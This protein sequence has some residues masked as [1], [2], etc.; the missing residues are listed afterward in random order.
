M[1]ASDP[2]I[3]VANYVRMSAL[4]VVHS[5]ECKLAKPIVELGG[6]LPKHERDI[7]ARIKPVL[8]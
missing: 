2:N 1:E 6:L 3:S 4:K 8:V 5:Q 7:A